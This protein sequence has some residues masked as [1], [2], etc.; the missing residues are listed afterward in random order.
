MNANE[1]L[2]NVKP[3]RPRSRLAPFWTDITTLRARGCT[4]AQVKVFLAKNGVEVSIAA[5]SKYIKK[6]EEKGQIAYGSQPQSEQRTT[7]KSEVSENT[8]LPMQKDRKSRNPLSGLAP[9]KENNGN[10]VPHTN[11][12]VDND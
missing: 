1:F 4:L 8:Q 12:E 11:F 2:E 9:S 3:A 6:M 7:G 5:I 10:S